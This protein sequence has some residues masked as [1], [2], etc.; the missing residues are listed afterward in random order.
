LRFLAPRDT[1]TPDCGMEPL[2]SARRITMKPFALICAAAL[3]AAT[4][5][6]A[7]DPA[8]TILSPGDI[9]WKDAP[10][11]VPRGAKM[12]VLKG[13]PAK[14]GLFILRLKAPDGYKIMPHWHPAFENVNVLSG[15]FGMGMGETFDKSKGTL[16][17][18]GGFASM[19]PTMRHFAW[20]EGETELQLTGYGPWQLYY[21]N[22]KDD[23][24]SQ[25]A[26]K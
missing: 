6:I 18:A 23:P 4:A 26:T 7:D 5:A 14:E 12:A 17:P 20:T 3:V 13:D 10:P 15:K 22:P 25:S 21:V 2:P 8:M 24:R 11:A 1:I 9:Q 16:I 19:P